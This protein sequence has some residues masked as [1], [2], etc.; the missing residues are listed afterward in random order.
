[1]FASS[2]VK[3]K[4]DVRDER[5]CI[6]ETLQTNSDLNIIAHLYYDILV[7]KSTETMSTV[8][9]RTTNHAINSTT[10]TYQVK[11]QYVSFSIV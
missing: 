3:S 2:I 11:A 10:G 1:M 9:Q 4:I 8:T 5:I 7:S 6:T